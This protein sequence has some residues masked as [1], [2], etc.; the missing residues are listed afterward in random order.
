MLLRQL[1]QRLLLSAEKRHPHGKADTGG[2]P[3]PSC[4]TRSPH[5]G[6]SE[7]LGQLRDARCHR[8]VGGGGG[9][10][11]PGGPCRRLRVS[12]STAAGVRGT[13]ERAELPGETLPGPQGSAGPSLGG[14]PWAPRGGAGPEHN[15]GPGSRLSPRPQCHLLR[16]WARRQRSSRSRSSSARSSNTPA[17]ERSRLSRS[18]AFSWRGQSRWLSRHS[19][20]PPPT[21]R[22]YLRGVLEP[23]LQPR[24]ARAPPAP[25]H[26]RGKRGRAAGPSSSGCLRAAEPGRAAAARGPRRAQNRA[27]PPGSAVFALR[28]GR[29]PGGPAR[30][31][32]AV[33]I[34][35]PNGP[36]APAP[37]GSLWARAAATGCVRPSSTGLRSVT[38]SRTGEGRVLSGAVRLRSRELRLL[39]QEPGLAPGCCWHRPCPASR[40]LHACGAGGTKSGQRFMLKKMYLRS[41]LQYPHCRAGE[42]TH[43]ADRPEHCSPPALGHGSRVAA[44]QELPSCLEG[45]AAAAGA[46]CLPP[47]QARDGPLMAPAQCRTCPW[48]WYSGASTSWVLLLCSDDM[49]SSAMG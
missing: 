9:S 36:R 34:P 21:P 17:S 37:L 24:D 13:T 14:H 5:F 43:T 10:R 25:L 39:L 31:P 49:F 29:G 44:R 19:P 28:A 26:G 7:A 46:E 16:R 8:G 2:C 32:A 38:E 23:L 11:G 15:P 48:S 1:P 6:V 18:R 30:I 42:L 35:R 40:L 4:P 45:S 12:F 3:R 33:L 22:I 20:Q 47:G 41:Y 27:V